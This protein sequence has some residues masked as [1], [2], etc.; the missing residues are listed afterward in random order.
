MDAMTI[1]PTRLGG[2]PAE[3]IAPGIGGLDMIEFAADFADVALI[4]LDVETTALTSRGVWDPVFRVRTIQL[5]PRDDRVWVLRLDDPEQER[6]VKWIMTDERATF[7]SHTQI[8]VLA[9]GI[10]FDVDISGR[11]IDTHVLAVASA[12]DDTPGQAQ[13]KPIAEKYGMPELGQV[14]IALYERFRELVRKNDPAVR[15]V[16]R[17]QRLAGEGFTGIEL[18]DDVFLEYAGLDALVVRRLVPLLVTATKAPPALLRTEQWLSA[19]AIRLRRRG[20]LVDISWLDRLTDESSV[21]QTQAADVM[22]QTCGLR[23]TQG[24]ALV[25]WLTSRGVE[26]SN[27][28]RTARGE[29]SLAKETLPA[30]LHQDLD[31]DVRRTIEAYG[32][33]AHVVNMAR[34]MTEIRACLDPSGR[35]HPTLITVGT[36]TGRMAASSPNL[37]NYSKAD[38]KMRG[39]FIPEPDHVLI[40]C[41]FAQIELRVVAALSG[42]RAMIDTIINGG[43]LHSLT[44][45]L[46]GITRQQAKVVNFLIVY[47]GGG[48]RLAEQLKF[49]ISVEQGK[50]IIAEYWRKYPAIA[51]LKAFMSRQ[52]GLRLISGRWVPTG[53]YADGGTRSHANLNYL[54]QGSARELLVG[55]WRRFASDADRERMAWFPIH[56]EL[57]LQ[58]PIDQ[59][60]EIAKEISEAMTFDFYG[61]PIEAEAD[62]LIDEQGSSRWMT[63][64]RA[65]EISAG[66]R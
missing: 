1:I 43:D 41:D 65:R 36:V 29:P 24:R 42:E 38:W 15:T 6:C 52:N 48:A 18:D 46:L 21:A 60:E 9:L 55:A 5:A 17:R 28:R 8:D 34:R 57:V 33:H 50:A 3:I 47:G 22:A 10:A 27:H 14:E 40:S 53:R 66:K 63:G 25:T 12:P 16:I 7:A 30:L 61:V 31:P 13:L 64:D 4:G 54:V 26:W 37:Q 2:E 56:D 35:V 23:P 20:H 58:V 51:R 49:E 19:Q 39:V 62:L 59:G 44:A 45:E 11:N 32:R